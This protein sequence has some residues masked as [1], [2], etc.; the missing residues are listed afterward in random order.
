M[1]ALELVFRNLMRHPV[2]SA[3]TVASLAVA[4]FLLCTLRSLVTT[5]ESGVEAASSSRMVVQSAVSLFVDLPLSYQNKIRS[6]PGVAEAAKWQWFGGY[7]QEP[8]NQFAQF[9][10]DSE[11]FLELFPEL[12]MIEGSKE[13]F[14]KN[15]RGCII[16]KGLVDR[17]GWKLGDTVPLIGTIFPHPDGADVAWE[18]EIEAIY[19]AETR[20]FDQS[21][22]LFHWEYFEKTVEAAGDGSPGVGIFYIRLEPGADATAVASAVDGLFENGPQRVQTTREAEFQAQFISMFGNVPFFVSAIGGA[23][24]LAILLAS[25]NTMLMA[26]R[27]Q[28]RDVGIMKALGFTDA[29]MFTLLIVQALVLCGLGGGIG[30]ALALAMQAPIADVLGS[31]FPGFAIEP[32][33]VAIA[34]TATLVVG[35]LAGAMPARAASRLRCVEALNAEA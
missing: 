18:F 20:N 14:D 24:L 2:R 27:E 32:A 8:S 30:I 22:L 19:E 7:Y 21:M 3:L 11:H 1:G 6:T 33:T 4:L 34:V 5:L 25:I 10:I 17:F 26:G 15:R 29:S 23:V 9:A 31:M 16:G 12:H 28:T 35:L 13:A